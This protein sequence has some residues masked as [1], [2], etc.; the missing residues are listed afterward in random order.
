MLTLHKVATAR[1]AVIVREAAESTSLRAP[2]RISSMAR[3]VSTSI[4]PFTLAC[5]YANCTRD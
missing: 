5:A 4:H 2:C 3:K 1:V